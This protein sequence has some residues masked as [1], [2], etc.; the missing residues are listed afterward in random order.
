MAFLKNLERPPLVIV[1]TAHRDYALDGHELNV[2]DYLLKPISHERFMKSINRVLIAPHQHVERHS[3]YIY[4]KVDMKM[5]QIFLDEICYIEGLSNYVKVHCENRMLISYQKL[6]HLEEV[7]PTAQFIRVHRSY[8]V[9]LPKIKAFTSQ[10]ME[11]GNASIPIG[12]LYKE[13]VLE[14]L[15]KFQP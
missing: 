13:N 15:S 3:A 2:V 7:L 5:V 11:I 10:E 8:I 4:L 14:K 9:S 1:T 6:N 12:G